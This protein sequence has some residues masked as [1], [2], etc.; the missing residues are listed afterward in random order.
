METE[1]RPHLLSHHCVPNTYQVPGC[2]KNLTDPCWLKEGIQAACWLSQW[3]KQQ[4]VVSGAR[5]PSDDESAGRHLEVWLCL[6]PSRHTPVRDA[7]VKFL[8]KVYI[9]N[10]D[11]PQSQN[12]LHLIKSLLAPAL[13]HQ[14]GQPLTSVRWQSSG[15]TVIQSIRCTTG[16]QRMLPGGPKCVYINRHVFICVCIKNIYDSISNLGLHRYY[17]L[18]W[19]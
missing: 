2:G 14:A 8:W 19:G 4:W 15:R 1:P 10:Q 18:G 16:E 6:L 3:L 13:G 17:C 11:I 9:F 12:S 5:T 7:A